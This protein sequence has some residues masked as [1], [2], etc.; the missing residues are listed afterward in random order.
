MPLA[1]LSRSGIY[2]E[3]SRVVPFKIMRFIGLGLRHRFGWVE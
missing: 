1:D 3:I 2:S